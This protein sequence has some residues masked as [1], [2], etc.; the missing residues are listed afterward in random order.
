MSEAP[1]VVYGDGALFER[2]CIKCG[3]IVKAYK[4]IKFDYQGQPIGNNAICKKHGRTQ[5]LWQGYY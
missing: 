2:R 1:T 5:M 4:K 3:R